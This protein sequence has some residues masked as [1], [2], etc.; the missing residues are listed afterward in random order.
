[1]N[2]SRTVFSDWLWAGGPLRRFLVSLAVTAAVVL[3]SF[4]AASPAAGSLIMLF[5]G[6]DLGMWFMDK[7]YVDRLTRR[8]IVAG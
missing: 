8:K 5:I 7:V 6:M 4:L 1:M 3:V 2:F